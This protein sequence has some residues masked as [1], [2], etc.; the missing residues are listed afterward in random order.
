MGT[1]TIEELEIIVSARIEQVKPQIQKVVQEIKDA[2]KETEGIGSAML[3]KID[4]EKI[5]NDAKRASK[6]VKEMF[7]P[8]DTSGMK[9]NGKNIIK[10]FSSINGALKGSTNE[11]NNVLEAY[12]Y[13]LKNVEQSAEVTKQKLS[14]IGHVKY[15]SASLQNFVDNYKKID[16][17]DSKG[18]LNSEVKQSS[19]YLQNAKQKAG[20]LVRNLRQAT[21]EKLKNG[22]KSIPSYISKISQ[23]IKNLSSKF[24]SVRDSSS[25]FTGVLKNGL[26]QIIKMAGALLGIRTIYNL[27]RNSANAWLN[28]QNSQAQQLQSNIEY[29]KYALGSALAPVIE[30]IVN[31]I[32]Q[33]LKGVQSLI[34]ALTGVNIFANASA[35]AYSNMANSA[36]N[37]QKATQKLSD[38]D[39][40]HNIQEDTNSNSGS[41]GSVSPNF[42]LS[43][44]ETA[45]W[46]QRLV[47]NIKNGNW[48]EIGATIGTK[49][50]ESLD[51]IPWDKIKSTAGKIGKN[52]A[53]FLNGGIKTI[54][55]SLVGKTFAEGVNTII[56]FAYNFVTTFD[57]KAAGQSIANAIN[58]FF[59]NI[60][61]SKLGKTLGD[62][63]KGLLTTIYTTIEEIDWWKLGE[64]VKTFIVNIDWNGV[65]DGLFRG[66]GAALGGLAAFLG[67]LLGEAIEGTKR[68]F[69]E[70]IEECGGNV[71]AGIFKG[72]A[73]ALV[74]IG[75]WIYEH[76]FK[77]IIE[78]FKNAFGIHSPS[79]VMAEQGNFIIEGF[80]NGIREFIGKVKDVWDEIKKA[81]FIKALEISEGVVNFFI[82][83]INGV[84]EA[85]ASIGLLDWLG[86]DIEPIEHVT[87]AEDYEKSLEQTTKKVKKEASVWDK[88]LNRTTEKNDWVKRIKDN[89]EAVVKNAK[90]TVD[91]LTQILTGGAKTTTNNVG[92]AISTTTQSI[93]SYVKNMTQRVETTF[94]KSTTNTSN[95]MT[96]LKTVTQKAFT[97]LKNNKVFPQLSSTIENSLKLND[98][99]RVWG[100]NTALQYKEGFASQQEQIKT[101]VNKAQTIIKNALTLSDKS[102]A[103]G[104]STMIYHN[105]GLESQQNS[106]TTILN[107][108]KAKVQS[109]LNQS[110]SSNYWGSLTA[111][112]Y[113][114]GINSQS[115]VITN[116]LNSIKDRAKNTLNNSNSYTWGRDMIQGFANGI[117]SMKQLLTNK[118][119]EVARI[120]SGKL[121]FSRP[122]EGPLRDY[123]TW[124]PD[125]IQGMSDSLL[126]SA[127]VLDSAVTNVAE[128]MA[129]NLR[130]TDLSFDVNSNINKN[131]NS[132][133]M[134]SQLENAVYS[135]IQKAESLFKLTINNE[136]KVNSKT[137]AKEILDD[138]NTEAKRRG[139]QAILQR[140]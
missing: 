20:E 124:M 108:I 9:I 50:N 59:N 32:Y 86:F 96:A 65:A 131:I 40:I 53:E 116:A 75:N 120:I 128:Q 61:W 129:E 91:S 14:S 11:L 16:S 102:K 134:G 10:G 1:M 45:N 52:L 49:I 118:V 51:K 12:R 71:V 95:F 92:Q 72:I 47:D 123:E 106:M 43:G 26:G 57:W 7:D 81:I 67:G 48:Y 6:K 74:N 54:D 126:K 42:D 98:K 3:G 135:A 46:I 63:V 38:I 58:G 5:A 109:S 39:E 111:S 17:L 55:W 2:V 104:T 56:E 127:P 105:K 73:D 4:T 132:N 114:D 69:K 19:S 77:P 139:Y 103:W 76:V 107:N 137:I 117:N 41:G 21:A 33:A 112:K 110:S 133:I 82:D 29:M 83:A 30:T 23:G 121:H 22:L 84:I 13:K 79:T 93:V 62:G 85:L 119:N 36:N 68:Y 138:L 60:D 70:K 37:A 122:D 66:L 31:L 136:L 89:N 100:K 64:N 140:G 101:I 130:A 90:E 125:M 115:G 35:K 97:D 27:L 44:V 8:N 25:K 94:Q 113:K 15:D 88:I 18:K 87:W 99:S 28:S 24:S 78:G 80:V 34:Y